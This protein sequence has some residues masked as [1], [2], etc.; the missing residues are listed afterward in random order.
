MRQERQLFNAEIRQS[1]P[2]GH[3][4][5][6]EVLPLISKPGSD[7]AFSCQGQKFEKIGYDKSHYQSVERQHGVTY[8]EQHA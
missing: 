1:Y 4:H 2:E 7:R 6:P 5:L 8:L 3:K